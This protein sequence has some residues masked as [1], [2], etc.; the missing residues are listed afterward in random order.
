SDLGELLTYT[1]PD[2]DRVVIGNFLISNGIRARHKQTFTN[3]NNNPTT[4]VQQPINL[5]EAWTWNDTYDVMT[6]ITDETGNLTFQA[7][8]ANGRITQKSWVRGLGSVWQ[9]HIQPLDVNGDTFVST[10]DSLLISNY[11]SA[12]GELAVPSLATPTAPFLDVNGDNQVTVAD[13]NLV[14]AFINNPVPV[15]NVPLASGEIGKLN[16]QYSPIPA[17]PSGLVTRQ[18]LT[19]GRSSGDSTMDYEYYN[20]PLDGARH[21][22]IRYV[23]EAS[24]TSVEAR[25]EYQYDDRGN[26]KRVI[27]SA[28]RITQ[29]TYDLRDR[30]TS[31]TQPDP[32]GAGNLLPSMI[33]YDYDVF[34]NVMATELI[35]SWMEDSLLRVSAVKTNYTYDNLNRLIS[36]LTQN[37]NVIWYLTI[38]DGVISQSPTKPIQTSS[39]TN[40]DLVTLATSNAPIQNVPVSSPGLQG[41]LTTHTYFPTG[42]PNDITVTVSN[43]GTNP[44][45][46]RYSYDRLNR[47]VKMVS[48]DPVTGLETTSSDQRL[49][50]GFVTLYEY[51]NI[52]NQ[53]AVT[54]GLN[55]K[56]TFTY[57]DANRLIKISEPK[58]PVDVPADLQQGMTP[59]VMIV[60]NNDAEGFS[61][62]GFVNTATGIGYGGSVYFSSWPWDGSETASWT[63]NAEPGTYRVAG[64]WRGE[65]NYASNVPI[66]LLNGTLQI[67]TATLNQQFNPDDFVDNGVWWE[68]IGTFTVAST[69]RIQMS[70]LANSYAIADAFRIE[71]IITSAPIAIIDNISAGFSKSGAW[72][73]ATGKGY[74]GSVYYSSWPFQGSETAVW[75]F[76]IDPGTYRVTGTW[77]GES[78]YASNVP[79]SIFNGTLQIGTATLNQQINP[80]DFLD[81]G[82]WWENVGTFTVDSTLRIQMSDLANSYAITDAFRIEKIA[83]AVIIDNS[84]PIFSRSGFVNTATGIG[85]AGS[86][87]FSSWPFDGNETASWTFNV[88]PG[89]YRVAGTWRGESNYASN[90]PI[91]L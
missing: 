39:I 51:D 15:N 69:L 4:L 10:I 55:N 26:L 60:D 87:Y 67:G 28:N 11:V 72:N 18:T 14:I 34:D 37:P 29:M 78:N 64:T 35:N 57:D 48:P 50:G 2:P 53:I 8:D 79:I 36:E 56:T 3:L 71:K 25:T 59:L 44:R 13:A 19:T 16:I 86:V 17:L 7:L 23:T 80:D 75:T 76:N 40:A 81:S 31:I 41:L 45:E 27:D 89:T 82:V 65:S 33:R 62:S 12:N 61:R 47:I 24:G 88:E 6:S 52:D 54:D 32:D 66:S 74:G 83:T 49:S 84:S 85:Y 30:I 21:G 91:S 20:V 70:D 9:N 73:S 42:A 22:K 58:V 68:N 43:A 77:A 90:V 1:S 38:S 63:F 5:N 46:T